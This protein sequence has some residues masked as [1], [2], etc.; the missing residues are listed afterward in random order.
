MQGFV[1]TLKCRFPWGKR[2]R[3]RQGIMTPYMK[4]NQSEADRKMRQLVALVVEV[5]I[6]FG[7]SEIRAQDRRNFVL[8]AARSGLVELIEPRTLQTVTRIHFDLSPGTAGLN[9]V[10]A[11]ADGSFLYVEGPI[12]SDSKGCC[13]LYAINLATLQANLV[14]GIPGS[15]SRDSL[16]ISDGIVYPAADFMPAALV[17]AYP[18]LSRNARMLLSPNGSF[19]FGV[20]SFVVP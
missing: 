8:A 11:S 4:D 13:D 19:L 2:R 15:S 14:A 20:R 10:A 1:N 6:L 5:A 16:V 9:G 17:G 3:L 12:R 18:G 7:G